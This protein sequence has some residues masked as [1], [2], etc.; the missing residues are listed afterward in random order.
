M[1]SVLTKVDVV[2]TYTRTAAVYDLWATVTESRARR[3]VAEVLNVRDGDSI[4]EVAAGTGL[5]FVDLL[6]RNPHGRNVGIDLTDAMLKHARDKAERTVAENWDLRIGDAY[7][8]DFPDGSFDAIVNCYMFDLIPDA[9]FGRVLGEFYRVLKPDGRLVL[10]TLVPTGGPIYRLWEILY[11]LNPKWVGGCRGV[12]VGDA[13]THAG[14]EI[15]SNDRVS[16]LTMVTEVLRARKARRS[17]DEMIGD[18]DEET[19]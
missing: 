1:P 12:C 13:V 5:L 2:E 18:G 3:R 4:L 9:D 10:A 19:S 11:G 17:R 14:F 6:E 15:E 16:Q 8:L 7:A